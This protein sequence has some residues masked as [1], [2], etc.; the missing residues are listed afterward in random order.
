MGTAFKAGLIDRV[1][2]ARYVRPPARDDVAQLETQ[3]A[4][5]RERLGQ[6]LLY[7]ASIVATVKVPNLEERTHLNLLLATVRKYSEVVHLVIEGSELQNS[8]QRVIISGMLIVTRTYDDGLA[9]HKSVTATTS[10]LSERLHRDAAPLI[11][12]AR[13]R[14][15]VL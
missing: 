8:L 13:D 3:L 2:F 9:V 7:V 15:L 11:Q 4:E 12:E 14:G 10:D 5:A 1:F 6:P